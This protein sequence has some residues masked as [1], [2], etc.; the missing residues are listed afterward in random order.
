MTRHLS[1]ARIQSSF[2]SNT[3]EKAEQ[4]NEGVN[5]NV[6]TDVCMSAVNKLFRLPD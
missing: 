1:P 6:E 3:Q 4:V 2:C 5:K